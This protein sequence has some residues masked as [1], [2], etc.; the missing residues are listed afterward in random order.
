[1]FVSNTVLF[2]ILIILAVITCAAG[3]VW[4]TLAI[5]WNT[6][7][8][9]PRDDEDNIDLEKFSFKQWCRTLLRRS[10][11]LS[12]FNKQRKKQ[13]WK[14][15]KKYRKKLDELNQGART[16]PWDWGFG[17]DYFVTYLEFMKEYYDLGWN[18]W[19]SDEKL[20][21][22][23]KTLKE[24]LDAYYDWTTW[25][26]KY[27]HHDEEDVYTW[28]KQEDGSIKITDKYPELFE[29]QSL[30]YFNEQ[31][32]IKRNKFFALVSENLEWWWD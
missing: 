16:R 27:F 7:Q 3:V 25:E 2:I 30:E 12:E 22:V 17:L 20:I 9:K 15:I 5:R 23:K 21:T 24:T 8:T 6:Q 13:Y 1:M 28:E 18:V 29:K 26:S 14:M 32:N 10:E 19:Q 11:K 4:V 31:Y